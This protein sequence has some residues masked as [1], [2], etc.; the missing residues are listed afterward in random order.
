MEDVRFADEEEASDTLPDGFEPYVKE[1]FNERFPGLS[2]PQRYS[3]DLIHEDE[4]NRTARPRSSRRRR[5]GRT[6]NPRLR[7]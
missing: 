3:F 4:K 6:E 5:S 7:T 1:W 2:P